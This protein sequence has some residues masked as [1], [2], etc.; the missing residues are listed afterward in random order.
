MKRMRIIF[1]VL[2][3]IL[4]II[5]ITLNYTA[6]NTYASEIWEYDMFLT[7]G[8]YTGFN[9][10]NSA[11]YFGTIKPGGTST[12]KIELKN[13]NQFVK[14]SMFVNG[15]LAEW[16]YTEDTSFNLLENEEKTIEIKGIV[17]KDA[18]LKNYEGK[19]TIKFETAVRQ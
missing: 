8:N 18:K 14:V 16:I 2:M 12:R 6:K 11:L 1:V 17:P 15:E 5:L 13:N 19:I 3:L 10:N 7:V 9:V 4:I